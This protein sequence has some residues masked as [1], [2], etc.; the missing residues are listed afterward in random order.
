MRSP[1]A[2]R[3]AAALDLVEQIGMSALRAA[4]AL[5]LI[6]GGIAA[7]SALLI[8]VF[9]FGSVFSVFGATTGMCLDSEP[10]LHLLAALG[11]ALATGLSVKWLS[12]RLSP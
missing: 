4:A 12:G 7:S 1:A 10:G 9:A 6:L 3:R 8:I 11:V 2:L 5:L